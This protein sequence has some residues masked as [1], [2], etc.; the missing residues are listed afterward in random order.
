MGG[1]ITT[2]QAVE[3]VY[4]D[5][6][7]DVDDRNAIQDEAGNDAASLSET[8]TNASTVA[9]TT[10]PT[11]VRAVLSSDGGTIVLTYDEVLDD[12]N[13]PSSG[14][15]AVTVDEQSAALSSSS[16]V[17][18]RG[19]TVALGLASAVTADQDVKRELQGS[20]RRPRRPVCDTGPG[21]Q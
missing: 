9:D 21:G 18:V 11:F 4:A 20:H 14:D 3:V 8:V 13:T 1:A 16:P 2:E 15:F 7:A 17:S 6:T 19:G 12:A 10:A 5:P